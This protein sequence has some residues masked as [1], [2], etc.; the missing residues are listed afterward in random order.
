MQ[1]CGGSPRHRCSWEGPP[2]ALARDARATDASGPTHGQVST[3]LRYHANPIILLG[4]N[5]G[6]TIEARPMRARVDTRAERL[7]VDSERV[8]GACRLRWAALHPSACHMSCTAAH[9][10]LRQAEVS[11]RQR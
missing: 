11:C 9:L 2:G 5:A 3:M 8:V 6:Y 10:C 4:N 1:R 7:E